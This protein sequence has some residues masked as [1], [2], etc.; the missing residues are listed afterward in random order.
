MQEALLVIKAPKVLDVKMVHGVNQE[1]A[2]HQI[3]IM[4]NLKT[5]RAWVHV[6]LLVGIIT[7]VIMD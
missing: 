5:D 1:Y 3:M 7:I 6:H 4:I 2:M